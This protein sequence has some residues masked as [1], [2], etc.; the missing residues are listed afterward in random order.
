MSNPNAPAGTIT[1]QQ[2]AA[3][4][5]LSPRR[6]QQLAAQGVIPKAGRDAYPLVGAVRGY[7]GWLDDE[8]RRAAQTAS[9]AKVAEARAQEIEQRIKAKMATLIPVEDHREVIASLLRVVRHEIGKV[10]AALPTYVRENVR[11]E[12]DGMME[13]IS[14]AAADAA[15]KTEL[16]EQIF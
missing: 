5:M 3:L 11:A 16:G 4:L 15:K 12:I 9:A 1:G 6:V 2:L 10:P 8:N 7:L 14:K 13:R